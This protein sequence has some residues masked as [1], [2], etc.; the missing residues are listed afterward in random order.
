MRITELPGASVLDQGLD[1]IS[2]HM[3]KSVH[4]RTLGGTTM[5]GRE[6]LG[7]DCS[8]LAYPMETVRTC[9]RCT[10]GLISGGG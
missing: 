7:I 2:R 1:R 5:I 4:V 6:G 10:H 8:M 9:D 3:Y